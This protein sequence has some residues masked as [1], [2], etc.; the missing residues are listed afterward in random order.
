MVAAPA[1]RKAAAQDISDRLGGNKQ[2]KGFQA[3]CPCHDDKHASLSIADG[4]DGKLLL[5]CHAGCKYSQAAHS[6]STP[7]PTITAGRFANMLR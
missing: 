6:T 1:E 4:E 3:R 7:E 2:G 5:Y